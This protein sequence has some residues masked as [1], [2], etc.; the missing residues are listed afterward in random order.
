MF[1]ALPPFPWMLMRD[2]ENLD[3]GMTNETLWKSTKNFD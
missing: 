1:G 2:H 3:G